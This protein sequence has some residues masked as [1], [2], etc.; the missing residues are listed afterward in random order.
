[1]QVEGQ[2]VTEI[3]AHPGFCIYVNT[4]LDGRVP[5]ERDAAG[6]PFV[7]VT[8]EEAEREL[9]QTMIDRL[10]EFLA[11]ERDFEDAMT[12]EDYIVE[13]D[14]H[15]DG[16]VTDEDGNSFGKDAL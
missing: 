12:V 1:M 15:P 9:A 4:V 6:Y 2:T 8:R 5:V 10:T 16:S 14:V 7:Y 3:D 13:V 11:G